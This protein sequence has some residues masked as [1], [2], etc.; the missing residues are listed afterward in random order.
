VLG[1]VLVRPRQRSFVLSAARG[2][3]ERVAGAFAAEL[4]APAE[5]IRQA[6]DA[7]GGRLDEVALDAIAGRFDVSLLVIR[8]QYDNQLAEIPG[9]A[10]PS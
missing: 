1:R 3:D 4:L 7:L 5:G 9:A 2:Y 8:H 6:L 10:F